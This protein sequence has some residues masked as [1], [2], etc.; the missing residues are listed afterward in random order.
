HPGEA[1]A[2]QP[3][4]AG[5]WVLG[6]LATTAPSSTE[7]DVE[8]DPFRPVVTAQPGAPNVTGLHWRAVTAS[9]SGSLDLGALFPNARAGSAR[10]LLRVYALREQPV[11]AQLGSSSSYRFW[12]N[13]RLV[14]ERSGV[15]PQDGDG[16]KVPLTLQ[17]GWNT[18]LFSVAV[19]N[20]TDWLSLTY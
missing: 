10:A 13:G 11:T 14:H 2:P 1:R 5:W 20:Q 3:F 8:P 18:L 15:R 4:Q 7:P 19:D 6:P 9:S 16:E 17:A 12:L